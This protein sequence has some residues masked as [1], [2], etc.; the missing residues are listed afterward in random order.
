MKI[1]LKRVTAIA[2]T[3]DGPQISPHKR[4]RKKEGIQLFNKDPPQ[5][6]TLPTLL[7]PPNL[8][9]VVQPPIS[10]TL[11]PPIVFI[12]KKLPKYLGSNSLLP[13]TEVAQKGYS[14][15][16]GS[17][18]LIRCNPLFKSLIEGHL[19]S[20]IEESPILNSSSSPPYF[21]NLFQSI[22]YQQVI[23]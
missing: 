7:D 9:T 21:L 15:E 18:H 20:L 23:E 13:S 16:L 11:L 5:V 1:P 19:P 2:P 10:T 14:L 12:P 17:S 22:V 6:L 3:D 4:T 8:T